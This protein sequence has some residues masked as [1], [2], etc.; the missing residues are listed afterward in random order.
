MTLATADEHG[1][2]WV[3]PVWYATDDYR[4]FFWVSSPDA[5]HS[6]NIEGRPELAIVI[7]DSRQAPYTGQGVYIAATAGRLGESALAGGI[8]TFSRISQ[9]QDLPAWDL[10]DVQSPARLRLYRAV[11]LQHFVLSQADQRLPVNLT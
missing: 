1:K 11:A 9:A 2:P 3:S 5:R 7:F 4:E 6:R 8:G 10:R